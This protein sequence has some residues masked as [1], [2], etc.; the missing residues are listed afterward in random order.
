[1]EK[2]KS[3]IIDVCIKTAKYFIATLLAALAAANLASCSVYHGCTISQVT[4]GKVNYVCQDSIPL[5]EAET[6]S[7]RIHYADSI[8]ADA[9]RVLTTIGDNVTNKINTKI[10]NW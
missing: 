8:I 9:Y 5:P 6:D 7:S 2:I 4:N 10:N 3:I 1:M